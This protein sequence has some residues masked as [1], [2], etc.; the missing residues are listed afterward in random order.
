MKKIKELMAECENRNLNCSI[1]YQRINNYSVEIYTGYEKK[2]KKIYY[3]DGHLRMK[4]AIKNGL[5]Y[6]KNY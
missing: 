3:S 2:Y 1:T 6:L 5:K 4:N